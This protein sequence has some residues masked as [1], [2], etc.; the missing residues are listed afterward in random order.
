MSANHG[1]AIER[2]D[3]PE[4]SHPVHLAITEYKA[5]RI[6]H[7]SGEAPERAIRDGRISGSLPELAINLQQ[8]MGS[9]IRGSMDRFI[10]L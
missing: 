8:I 4:S 6:N 10:M 5:V 7:L 1:D 9:Q 2:P 3:Y